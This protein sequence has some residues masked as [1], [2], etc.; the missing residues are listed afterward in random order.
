MHRSRRRRV[1]VKRGE[2]IR[3]EET[4]DKRNCWE[5]MSR[6]RGTAAAQREVFDR[7]GG[8]QYGVTLVVSFARG[9]LYKRTQVTCRMSVAL[10]G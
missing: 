10:Q 5:E 3:R 9:N 7:P 2:R 4:T 8:K 1:V 6:R